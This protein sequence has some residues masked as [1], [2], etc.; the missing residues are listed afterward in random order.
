MTPTDF[1]KAASYFQPDPLHFWAWRDGG[2]EIVLSY[3]D[4][5]RVL[6]LRE[7]LALILNELQP[8]G[9]PPL[10]AI[11]LIC[12]G[13]RERWPELKPDLLQALAT[14]KF[15]SRLNESCTSHL[16]R[17]HAL[18]ADLRSTPAAKARLVRFIY[19]S[20]F[21]ALKPAEATSAL[22]YLHTVLPFVPQEQPPAKSV[23]LID[24]PEE[25]DWYRPLLGG[26][27]RISEQALRNRFETGLEADV[28]P[29]PLAIPDLPAS[30]GARL[31]EWSNDLELY[32]LARIARQLISVITWPRPVSERQPLPLGGVADLTNRGSLDRLLLSELAQDDDVLMV[33][34]ALNESLY[35][36]RE[37][38]EDPGT[39]QRAIFVDTSLR[40][41]GLPRVYAAAVALTLAAAEDTNSDLTIRVNATGF[42][43]LNDQEAEAPTVDLP[44][45]GLAMRL[46][47]PDQ[48]DSE[49]RT[50]DVRTRA[51]VQQLLA[52]LSP[53]L[54]PTPSIISWSQQVLEE[55]P[56]SE[57]VIVTA[58]EVFDQPAFQAGLNKLPPNYRVAIVSRTGQ[59]EL[60]SHSPH[61][62][63]K[64]CAAEL[65]LEELLKPPVTKRRETT[66][67]G[68]PTD[69]LPAILRAD[70][71]PLLLT[72]SLKLEHT[73][74]AGED[75]MISIAAGGR[76]LLWTQPHRG[77]RQLIS[78]LPKGRI[79]TWHTV[80]DRLPVDLR[81]PGSSQP[82]YAVLRGA[83]WQLLKID[84]G[85][86][87]LEVCDLQTSLNPGHHRVQAVIL[88]ECVVFISPTL[89]EV[90]SFSTGELLA[91]ANYSASTL[92][93]VG[94]RHLRDFKGHWFRIA[95]DGALRLQGV[96]APEKT[97]LLV[98]TPG[99]DPGTV[100][101]P[102][103][104]V[105]HSATIPV[106]R[107]QG[108]NLCNAFQL[109]SFVALTGNF[110]SINDIAAYRSLSTIVWNRSETKSGW[111]QYP[112]SKTR[113]AIHQHLIRKFHAREPLRTKF[114]AIQWGPGGVAL[115]SSSR[116]WWQLKPEDNRIV[117]VQVPAAADARTQNFERLDWPG[118]S[119]PMM[120]ARFPEGLEIWLDAR[121]LLHLLPATPEQPEVTLVLDPNRISGW[122]SAG[123]LFGDPYYLL[124]SL[125][126]WKLLSPQ[127]AWETRIAPVFGIRP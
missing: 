82:A 106:P 39:Q 29:A 70:P 107:F 69:R 2:A 65:D 46:K 18:P 96:R 84:S 80:S 16:D 72:H 127:A 59:F 97:L 63:K 1:D 119:I 31:F 71:F 78:G 25:N 91:K 52:A 126:G 7:E 87:A 33:R 109:D 67:T 108:T 75:R 81:F 5:H 54:D 76:A 123:E 114:H 56:E 60:V 66:I 98:D 47:F 115:R 104:G 111:S 95:F 83:K 9:W 117:L 61:G 14:T 94:N 26:I 15:G 34:L 45:A 86:S 49:V 10:S 17:I 64:L 36:R 23:E 120:L 50:I 110:E 116:N 35:I 89:M 28:A 85:T 112:V 12:A 79:E 77:G 44:I 90:C 6:M 51:G 27:Q 37:Q 20:G 32:G 4:S 58:R 101:I 74:S 41:W 55:S 43:S 102:E 125:A 105:G 122:T 88:P 53:Y 13:A 92:T 11:L 62:W 21:A 103:E 8:E 40:L 68:C 42:D 22:D 99:Q 24:N 48:P 124:N 3:G 113:D 93:F 19:S 100:P 30:H 57:L 38:P 118:L 121:G 73:F